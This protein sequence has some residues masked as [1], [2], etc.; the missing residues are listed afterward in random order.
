METK[1]L[2]KKLR[3]SLQKN[4]VVNALNMETD[5]LKI[6]AS[7]EYLTDISIDIKSNAL[8]MVTQIELTIDAVDRRIQQKQFI[9]YPHEFNNE[10][11]LLAILFRK[12]TNY[13]RKIGQEIEALRS[14]LNLFGDDYE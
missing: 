9:V 1:N 13:N 11:E 8:E 2:I 12:L 5:C 14:Q 3:P 7:F 4:K 6:D 10:V